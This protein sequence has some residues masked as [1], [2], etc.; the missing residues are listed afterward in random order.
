MLNAKSTVKKINEKRKEGTAKE[1]ETKEEDDMQIVGEVKSAMQVAED[2]DVNPIN[3]FSLQER[4]DMLNADQRRV[5]DT[6]T[7]QQMP[8]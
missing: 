7:S 3:N 8:L 1:E 2:M 6:I 4:I 5:Y